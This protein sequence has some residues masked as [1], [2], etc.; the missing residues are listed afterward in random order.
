M[1]PSFFCLPLSQNCKCQKFNRKKKTLFQ[2]SK[3]RKKK[4]FFESDKK[5]RRNE[6]NIFYFFHFLLLNRWLNFFIF[7]VYFFHS[8]AS[9]FFFLFP[10]FIVAVTVVAVV[11][12]I[13]CISVVRLATNFTKYIS[14]NGQTK[15]ELER[16]K[17]HVILVLL[18]LDGNM[19]DWRSTNLT[20][21]NLSV[22]DLKKIFIEVGKN[23]F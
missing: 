9:T 1:F 23:F 5:K 10:Y 17:N 19:G 20:F 21:F 3:L 8:A 12:I 18:L 6:R 13:Y 2:F 11:V 22:M 4:Q 15:Y 14:D 7:L 16:K